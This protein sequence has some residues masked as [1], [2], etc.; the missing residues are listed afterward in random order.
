MD[1]RYTITAGKLTMDKPTDRQDAAD[2]RCVAENQFGMILSDPVRMSFGCKYAVNIS[3]HPYWS[4]NI[5]SG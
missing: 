1:P 5:S 2:Y 4:R 3:T